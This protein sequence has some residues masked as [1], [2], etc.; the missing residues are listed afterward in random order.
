M[1]RVH[2]VWVVSKNCP[3]NVHIEFV[4]APLGFVNKAII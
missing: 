2:K 1:V 3:K 4:K